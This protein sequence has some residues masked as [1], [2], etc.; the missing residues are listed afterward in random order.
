[1]HALAVRIDFESVL[2]S[3]FESLRCAAFVLPHA[4]TVRHL[5][6]VKGARG[7]PR[8]KI[9]RSRKGIS[10]NAAIDYKH[11]HYITPNMARLIDTHALFG[12]YY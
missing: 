3:G 2:C 1:M 8:N 9:T 12:N 6:E 4:E 10:P 5:P 11:Q 7:Y